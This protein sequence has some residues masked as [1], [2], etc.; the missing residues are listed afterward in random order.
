MT[1]GR[2]QTACKYFNSKF[3]QLYYVGAQNHILCTTFT[4]SLSL[5]QKNFTVFF[6][7]IFMQFL[8]VHFQSNTT[9]LYITEYTKHYN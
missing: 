4:I 8:Q 6:Y 7:L 3:W 1:S 5:K 9:S 2:K